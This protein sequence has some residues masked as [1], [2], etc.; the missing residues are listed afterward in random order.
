MCIEGGF[1]PNLCKAEDGQGLVDRKI[2]SIV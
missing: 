1:Y 2:V